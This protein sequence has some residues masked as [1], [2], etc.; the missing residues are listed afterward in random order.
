[1]KVLYIM[2]KGSGILASVLGIMFLGVLGMKFYPITTGIAGFL[3]FSFR[4][5]LTA[6]DDEEG[7]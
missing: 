1:M 5:G 2:L 3:F 6:T 7:K 4:V